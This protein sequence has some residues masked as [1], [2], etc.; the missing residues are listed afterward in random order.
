SGQDDVVYVLEVN[1]RAS[2]TVPFVSKATGVPLAKIAARCMA[3]KSLS[4]Q[5]VRAEVVPPYYSVKE[6]VFPFIKFPGADTILGP[7]MKSTGEVMGVGATFAEAFVKSQMASGEKLPSSGKV[8]LSVRDSDKPRLVEIARSLH[9]LGFVL[10]AT[11]GTAAAV[12]AAGLPVVP[13]NKVA[14]GRPH[15]VDM[16]KNGEIALIVN[17]V[18]DRRSAIRNSY[19]IRRAALQQRVSLFTTL[20]GARAG[21]TG[22]EHARE[23][24]AYRVQQLHG[25]LAP[26]AVS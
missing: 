20:A 3:G 2:R 8:F 19:A 11:R 23:L 21:C 17:T 1:P 14:E 12:A 13:V 26:E 22:M 9:A 7:E 5:G 16:I 4:E 6:A 15:I 18:E 24:R 25:S 10:V